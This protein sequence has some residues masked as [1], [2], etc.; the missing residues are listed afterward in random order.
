MAANKIAS[1]AAIKTGR[2]SSFRMD[3]RGGSHQ[4]L[5]SPPTRIVIQRRKE[6]WRR[7]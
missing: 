1:Q 3:C 7:K 5:K 6:L 2:I 4:R